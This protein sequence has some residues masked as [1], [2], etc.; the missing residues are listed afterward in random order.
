MHDIHPNAL[1]NI[2][3]LS[4]IVSCTPVDHKFLCYI[5]NKLDDSKRFCVHDPKSLQVSNIIVTFR[6]GS[7]FFGDGPFLSFGPLS[8]GRKYECCE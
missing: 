5:C 7:N 4:K 1:Q 6:T 3:F 2:P 8:C